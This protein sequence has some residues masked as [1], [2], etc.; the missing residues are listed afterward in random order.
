MHVIVLHQSIS[1]DS[2]ADDVDVLTQVKAVSAALI[3]NDHTLDVI[4]CDLNLEKISVVLRK[5]E[6]DVVFNL[7][8]SL[9]GN[10]SMLAIVPMLLDALEVRYTGTR[11]E[12][13]MVTTHKLQMKQRLRQIRLPTPGWKVLPG[14]RML[15]DPYTQHERRSRQ[16]KERYLIKPIW[17]HGSV[18][19]ESAALVETEFEGDLNEI[20]RHRESKLLRPCFAERYVDGREFNISLL[21][22]DGQPAVLPPAEIRFKGF[23]ADRPKLVDYRAKWDESSF[24]YQ[25]TVPTFQFEAIDK[26]LLQQLRALSIQCWNLFGLSGYARIDF[27]VDRDGEPWV[28]D[29]NANPCLSPGAGFCLALQTG[30]IPFSQAIEHI[31]RSAVRPQIL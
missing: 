25:N 13:L 5:T 16:R 27:R 20:I 3:E 12:A 7:V 24:E 26:A 23:S 18:G 22:I 8:E 31:V 14:H 28:I 11:T 2:A 29:V 1:E 15:A 4:S 9:A 17:E 30:Q 21:E 19:I 10:G 6:S